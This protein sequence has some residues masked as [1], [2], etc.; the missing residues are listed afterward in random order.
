MISRRRGS[1]VR[2]ITASAAAVT[3]SGLSAIIAVSWIAY[4]IGALGYLVGL[5]L[6]ARFDLPSGAVVVL[7]MAA[8]A[9]LAPALARPA[10]RATPQPEAPGAG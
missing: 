9:P 5:A 7:A 4:G 10:R 2:A 1:S 8:L 6:S 3:S